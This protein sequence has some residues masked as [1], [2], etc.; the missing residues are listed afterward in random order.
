MTPTEV[1]KE[2]R[3]IKAEMRTG[4]I[5]QAARRID[6]LSERICATDWASTNGGK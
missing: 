1:C 3:L 4:C 5:S 2:L 6:E